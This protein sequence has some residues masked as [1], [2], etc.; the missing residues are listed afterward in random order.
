MTTLFSGGGVMGRIAQTAA[1]R[2]AGDYQ[3]AQR[4]VRPKAV[5][6]RA[7]LS[8]A[9]E[10][11]KVQASDMDAAL[12]RI[13]AVSEFSKAA[14]A[15]IV[16]E[17]VVEDLAKKKSIFAEVS[18]VVSEQAIMATNTS[19]LGVSDIA[20]AVTRPE[21]FLGLHFFN[22]VPA[23]KLVEVIRGA[24]TSDST[25]AAGIAFVERLGKTPCVIRYTEQSSPGC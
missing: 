21:R 13:E 20:S 18:S 15:A 19:A 17:A 24:Q 4:R 11:G 16:I 8:R 22:P 7:S 25:L 2:N 6:I 12:M 10:K 3:G 23:M 1:G 9:V 5:S 14:G